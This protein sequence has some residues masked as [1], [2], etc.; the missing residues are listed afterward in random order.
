MSKKD[1]VDKLAEQLDVDDLVVIGIN[2]ELDQTKVY[3]TEMSLVDIFGT[4]EVGKMAVV[5]EKV[6][7]VKYE[8]H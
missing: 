7:S 5:S 3:S 1:W 4:L 8:Q 2:H 6:K